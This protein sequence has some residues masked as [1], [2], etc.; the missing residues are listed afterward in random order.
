[1]EATTTVRS[2]RGQ[3]KKGIPHYTPPE[4][5]AAADAKRRAS[6][7][8]HYAFKELVERMTEVCWE[9]VRAHIRNE[10]D[11]STAIDPAVPVKWSSAPFAAQQKMRADVLSWWGGA[12]L[13]P[14]APITAHICYA[15]VAAYKTAT[16]IT[17]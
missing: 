7:I 4:K 12:S 16:P 1:M 14:D 2:W 6:L 10:L 13:L 5:R 9:A 15:I 3:N 17:L 11:S 8:R